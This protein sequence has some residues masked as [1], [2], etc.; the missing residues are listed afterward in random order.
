MKTFNDIRIGDLNDVIL[1]IQE[2][3]NSDAFAVWLSTSRA[4]GKI[5]TNSTRERDKKKKKLHALSAQIRVVD[6][7][8]SIKAPQT[9]ILYLLTIPYLSRATGPRP[10]VVVVRHIKSSGPLKLWKLPFFVIIL[11]VVSV[12]RQTIEVVPSYK[13]GSVLAR[14][15]V[16]TEHTTGPAVLLVNISLQLPSPVVLLLLRIGFLTW[17]ATLA[18]M[19]HTFGF[20]TFVALSISTK[21]S[22]PEEMEMILCLTLH[23]HKHV[24][25]KAY[26][27]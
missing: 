7:R 8:A 12:R 4:T 22:D 27:S 25:T 18:R 16:R 15:S 10:E 6:L 2:S 24:N 17:Y 5:S 3:L 19:K 23:V 26:T 14:D 21:A 13:R 9:L 1:V 11:S 20:I